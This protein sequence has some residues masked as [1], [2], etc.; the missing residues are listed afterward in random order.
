MQIS[1]RS[2]EQL[3]IP[4]PSFVLPSNPLPLIPITL[5]AFAVHRSR[6]REG[7][8]QAAILM[9]FLLSVCRAAVKNKIIKKTNQ[10]MNDYSDEWRNGV[11]DAGIYRLCVY[12]RFFSPELTVEL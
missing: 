3:F 9:N 5:L 2:N 10:A 8:P 12:F 7:P 11:A 4:P 6:A 1:T